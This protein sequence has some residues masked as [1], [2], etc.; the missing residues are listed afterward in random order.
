[1]NTDISGTHTPPSYITIYVYTYLAATPHST[2]LTMRRTNPFEYNII[3]VIAW[4]TTQYRFVSYRLPF[5]PLTQIPLT[6]NAIWG[7][8]R[9]LVTL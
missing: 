6:S 2:Q 3:I 8:W 9:R 7:G 4:D 5:S 1:M